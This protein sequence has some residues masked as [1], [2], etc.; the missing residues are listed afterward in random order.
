[1]DSIWC[2]TT[3]PSL[4]KELCDP[5]GR[6]DHLSKA[7]DI[8][9]EVRPCKANSLAIAS[10]LALAPISDDPRAKIAQRRG[11]TKILFT[12]VAM[13]SKKWTLSYDQIV[14]S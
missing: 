13:E 14:M 3:D 9:I 1:M 12:Y 11:E 4:K 7:V 5:I 10:Q 8:T 2:Y 6:Y